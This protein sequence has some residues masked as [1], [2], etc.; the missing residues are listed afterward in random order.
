MVRNAFIGLGFLVSTAGWAAGMVGIGVTIQK[1]SDDP[2]KK[3]IQIVQLRPGAP[4]ERAG[5]LVGELIRQVDG[6]EVKGKD[7]D[8]VAE[9]IRGSA[10]PGTVV[11]LGMFNPG[12]QAARDVDVTRE[13][14]EIACFLEGRV[15]LSL[16]GNAQNGTLWG[17][18]GDANVMLNV[19]N[20]FAR[21]SING[22]FVSLFLSASGPTQNYTLSGYL[23]G[24][25]VNWWGPGGSFFGVLDCI[26][27]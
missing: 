15:S 21:G 27:E 5:L 13:F 26:P 7:V 6:T 4:A 14:I 10:Q 24:H 11:R 2:Y 9:L 18:I 12:T 20:G 16:R 23:H 19:L 3:E 25:Y 22:E 17:Y 8:D 1:R